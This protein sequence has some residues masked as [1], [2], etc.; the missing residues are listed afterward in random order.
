MKYRICFIGVL[1]AISSYLT[2][3]EKVEI[4]KDEFK[5]PK[6][7]FKDAWDAIKEGD[8]LF[9]FGEAGFRNALYP[10]LAAYQYNQKNAELNY[11]IGICY[12][13]SVEKTKAIT[14]FV[15][16]VKLKPNVAGDIDYFLGRAYHLTYQF[17]TAM[18][19]FQSYKRKAAAKGVN[20]TDKDVDK[21][22]DECKYA[23]QYVASPIRVFI[24]NLGDNINSS[25]PDY[26]PVITADESVIVYCSRR[27]G[28]VGDN[29]DPNDLQ[30]YEDL[31]T[32]ENIKGRGW[33][34]A[35]NMSNLNTEYHDASVGISP[36]GQI[37]FTYK[38]VPD[39]TIFQSELKGLSWGKPK[40]LP[41][42]INTK[43]DESDASLTYDM[44]YLYFVSN[45]PEDGFKTPT[46]GG[47]DIFI[48]NVDAKGNWLPCKNIG[49][50]INTKYDERGVFLHPDGNTMYFSSQGHESMGG[51]DI[52]YSEK[53]SLG[54]WGKPVNIGYP[55]NTP[56]DDVFFVAA[57]NARFGYYSSSREGGR[58]YQD[59]YR[60]TFL[61]PEKL[62]VCGSEDNL[63]AGSEMAVQQKVDVQQTVEVRKVRLTILKGTIT[64]YLSGEPVEAEIEIV[65]NE[66]N[67]V[68]SVIK[69]NSSTGKYLVSLPSGKNYG[70]AV[71]APD[72]L[73]YSENFDIPY[74]QD[75]QEVTKDIVLSKVT[76]GSKII[77]KNIFFDYDKATIRPESENEL[78]RLVTLLN[79][80]PKMRIEIGGHT[81]SH[82]SLQYNTKL[83]SD[84]AK[85]VVDY[86][87][88]KGIDAS[89]LEYKGYAF[90]E[91]IA[92]NDTDEGRQQNRR[93]EFKVLSIK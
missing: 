56:D 72:Y 14:H 42:Q 1:L 74:S 16:A 55:V 18:Y 62:M 61:G 85:A 44:K 45:R 83:S 70:I 76:V 31:Y 17:D 50:I 13:Y 25:Y 66:K 49:G 32:S 19:Y 23:K 54:K 21:R 10:Y 81:D 51:F 5:T 52:F 67:E 60:I 93:V 22:I 29:I 46:F 35:I 12:L 28:G 73:F 30:Y 88:S 75:Y 90:N 47:K 34:P 82:G 6:E 84:R 24:D 91:P 9:D 57:G 11:K 38:G 15:D 2:G 27:P 4:L 26:A 79:A 36:D 48:T 63:L 43:Y 41:S 86:L 39:G 64:D 92:T 89:R 59:I 53:D 3:Q 87:V 20:I 37:M 40:E 33:S 65:D 68:I 71:K 69:S 8:K 80:Y 58:G 77:L 78:T 7:G